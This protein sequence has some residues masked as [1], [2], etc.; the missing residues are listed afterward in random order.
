MTKFSKSQKSFFRLDAT[1]LLLACAIF[2]AMGEDVQ[3]KPLSIGALYEF[4][5]LQ[6]GRFRNLPEFRQEWV[7]HF[8]AFFTQS[9]DAG[10]LWTVNVGLGGLFEFQKPEVAGALWG[11]TQNRNFS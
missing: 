4:G 5:M 2:P 8:G 10:D 6:G 11:G 7:D 9:T 3:V 1:V